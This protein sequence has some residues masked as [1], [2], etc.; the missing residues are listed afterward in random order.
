MVRHVLSPVVTKA[1]AGLVVGCALVLPARAHAQTPAPPPPA[2]ASGGNALGQGF[3]DAGQIVISVD[4]SGGPPFSNFA[5]AHFDK[6]NHA[7]WLFEIRPA[8]DY[9]LM[10]A[11]TVGAVLG[12]ALD[13]A[14][15]KGFL[16]GGRGGFNFNFTD[17]VGIWGR[18]AFSLNHVSAGSGG[19]SI[20]DTFLSL[21]APVLYH[22][23]PH[24][25]VGIGPY[26][27]LNTSGP[28]EN[29][30]GFTCTVGG[31]F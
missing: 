10:P 17:N 21:S 14:S 31:W 6:V 11:V 28:G 27:N 3:G 5:G 25:F 18:A 7:G 1:V 4:T 2:A 22:P 30:Y 23:A 13:D 15:N 19:G 9:F 29:N 12:F 16:V 8:A 26:Y 24:M 20:N